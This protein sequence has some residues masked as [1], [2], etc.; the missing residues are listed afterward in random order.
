MQLLAPSLPQLFLHKESCYPSTLPIHFASSLTYCSTTP[1]LPA[2]AKPLPA[3]DCTLW[4]AD[5]LAPYDYGTNI[6]AAA[7]RLSLVYTSAGLNV[8]C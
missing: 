3:S 1:T 8:A 2:D 6:A 4:V 5:P 7:A